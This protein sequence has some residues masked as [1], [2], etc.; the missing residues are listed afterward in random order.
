MGGV[1]GWVLCGGQGSELHTLPLI[2]FSDLDNSHY[3]NENSPLKYSNPPS[4]LL[5]QHQ[6][7]E[8][9]VQNAEINQ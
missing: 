4:D 8:Q 3:I 1:G 2:G 7:E 9:H 5:G 6:Q